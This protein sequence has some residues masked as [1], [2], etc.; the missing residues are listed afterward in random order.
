MVDRFISDEHL[1]TLRDGSAVRPEVVAARG[2]RTVNAVDDVYRAVNFDLNSVEGGV[3]GAF[4]ER[5]SPRTRTT[6]R[7]PFRTTAS[8]SITTASVGAAGSFGPSSS[9]S[10]PC[11][12]RCGGTARWSA[13][14]CVP[15]DRA[16]T[17]RSPTRP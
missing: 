13:T 8:T 4:M 1:R 2:Y 17:P 15:I 10:P 14:G 5:G 7:S 9:G 12:C 11:C 6:T 3:V 16:R